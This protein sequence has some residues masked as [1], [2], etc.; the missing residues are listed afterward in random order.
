MTEDTTLDPATL[1]WEKMDGLL[2]AVVQD[3]DTDQLLMLGYMDRAALEVTLADGMVTFFS[4][5][6][7]RLWRKGESSGNVLRVVAIAADCDSDA[8]LV[9]ARPAGPT[10]HLGSDSCFGA[11]SAG[12]GWLG[13]LERIIARRSTADPEESYTARLLAA[14]P[15]K[16]AQKVGEEGVEVAMAA[17][18]RDAQG[19]AEEA[20]DLL[21]HLLVTLRSRG[22]TLAEVTDVLRQRHLSQ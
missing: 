14:G 12:S 2:P 3:A 4:R 16:A 10:C 15:A 20:A 17:V 8:L 22:V 18:S 9:R 1:A 21:F 13:Q 11:V 7:N 6:K 5:S 19:L